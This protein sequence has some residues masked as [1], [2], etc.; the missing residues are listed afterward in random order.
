MGCFAEALGITLPYCATI[1][2]VDARRIRLAKESGIQIMQ[3][4]EK[5]ITP[6]K[7]M[8][9][10]AFENAIRVAL[11]LGGSTNM[12]LHIPAIAHELNINIKLEMFDQLSRDTPYICRIWPAGQYTMKDL[13]DAGG[14]PG[15][16]STI[17]DKLNL[18]VLTATG[19]TLRENLK[20][21]SVTNVEVI[22]PLDKPINKEGGLAVLK[23]SL[24][25]NGAIVRTTTIPSSMLKFKGRAKVFDREEDAVKAIYNG[26]LEKGRVIVIRYE[27][28]KGGPGMREMIMS[29][30][31]LR[32]VRLDEHVA[33]ITDGRFSGATRGPAIGHVSPEAAE[34]GPIAVVKDDDEIL[35]DIV[36]RKLELLIPKEEINKRI[37]SWVRPPSTIKKGYLIRYSQNVSSADRGAV[38]LP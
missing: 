2:A 23:G 19:A 3:L 13:D 11:A 32:H 4:L 14:I 25:P 28:P 5:E 8:T 15:V 33:L 20:K 17:K 37:K 21:A 22:R 35:I 26:D 36:N 34:G 29:P 10:E 38:L 1:P 7:I 12:V 6:S 27:G 18:D 16:M 31:A 9:K 24:A 30:E